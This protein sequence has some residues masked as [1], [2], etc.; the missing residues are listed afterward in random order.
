MSHA[1]DGYAGANGKICAVIAASCPA[2]ANLATYLSAAYMDSVPLAAITDNVPESLI[3][4][5]SFQEF[6]ISWITMSITKHNFVVRKIED[7]ADILRKVFII[8][9]T[10]RKSP[11]LIDILKNFT[12]EETEF[13]SKEKFIPKTIKISENYEK[14]IKYVAELINF[15]KRLVIYFGGGAKDSSDKLRDFMINSNIPSVH[16]IIGAC[17]LGYNEKLNVGLIGMHGYVT[18]NKVINEADL[19]LAIGIRFSDRA[20]LNT[21]KFGGAAKKVLLI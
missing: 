11:I 14:T 12:F 16:T 10:G 17:V 7:L 20:A 6:L 15:S 5:D 8:A 13:K 1:A 9:S 4:K 18:A 19:I 21:S 3:G 2:A